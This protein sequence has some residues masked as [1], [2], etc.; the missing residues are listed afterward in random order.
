M[1]NR[2]KDQRHL[3]AVARLPCL[4][5]GA[6]PVEVAHVRYADA[7]R[8]KPITGMQTK[9]DDKWTVPLCPDHH[10]LGP[11]AQ[12]AMGERAFW[13]SHDI[14]PLAVCEALYYAWQLTDDPAKAEAAM[15][16][17]IRHSKTFE[18]M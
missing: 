7:A 18:R 11:C 14:D 1:T 10:R 8:D 15:L 17:V 6:T 4:I 3:S 13:E 16:P 9:P 5:C 2:V 12:H